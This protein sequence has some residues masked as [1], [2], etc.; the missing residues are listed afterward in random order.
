M[1]SAP[2]AI[3][4]DGIT[5]T[6]VNYQGLR[7]AIVAPA[8]GTGH[9]GMVLVAGAGP[10]GRD[11]YRPEAEAFAR[12]GIV[13]LIYDKRADYSRAT[14]SYAA[15]ADD[16][17]TGVELLRTRPDVN[18]S[19]VG[20]WGHSEGGWVAPL[21]AAK[22]ADVGFV[23]TVG[24]SALP[25]DRTQLWS[26][27]TYLAHAGVTDGL[28]GPIGLNASRMLISAGL[29]GDTANDPI[30]TL[31]RVRQPLLVVFGEYD[32]S[33]PPGESLDLFRAA[34]DRGGNQHYTLRVVGGA[35]HTMRRSTDGFDNAHGPDFAPGFVNL[36]TTWVNGPA[37]GAPPASADPP[38]AQA[39]ASSPT[40]PLSWYE[41]P[42]TQAA[43]LALMV[44]GLLAYPACAAA[45]RLRGTRARPPGRWPARWAV[46][47]V[48][49]AVIGTVCY[50]LFVVAT[51]ATEVDT[52]I[53]GRPPSW[54]LL[55]LD[56]VG[57]VV[58]AGLAARGWRHAPI[59]R[60]LLLVSVAAFL[61]WAAYW[62]LFTV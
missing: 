20:V 11:S 45:R 21:A 5:N 35:N 56:A 46:L 7:G 47:G 43:L 1:S 26:D 3:A 16:A 17:V 33:M 25:S 6:E 52:T 54:L 40:E 14:S 4:A 37:H 8:G 15:L 61:P 31:T 49:T 59:Q 36:V 38:P 2:P 18:P 32:R 42:I 57:A 28:V 60:G 44:A 30:A 51:G 50:A 48:L 10:R 55:Q 53:L 41:G 39:L 12:A 9:P 34:L 23:V 22:S 27:R 58:A 13:V 29:F 19:E 62:G 24:A